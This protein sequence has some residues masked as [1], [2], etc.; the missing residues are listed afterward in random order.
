MNYWFIYLGIIWTIIFSGMSIYWAMGGM[1]GVRSLGGTIYEIAL[2]PSPSFLA[3][4]WITG[5]IKLLGAVLLLMLLVHRN[6]S[7]VIRKLFYIVKTG[8]ALLFLYG[9]LNFITISLHAFHILNFDLDQ[10]ATFWRLVFWEPFWMAGGVFYFF[11]VNRTQS[12]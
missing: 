4:V 7:E 2:N 10:Y 5:F 8:G 11:S 6:N 9:A 12:R 3:I 1:L